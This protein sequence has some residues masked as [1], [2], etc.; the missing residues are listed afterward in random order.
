MDL[1]QRCKEAVKDSFTMKRDCNN[2]LK[3]IADETIDQCFDK[4]YELDVDLVNR[5]ST[6]SFE[7]YEERL[8]NQCVNS[9]RNVIQTIT[10]M[11]YENPPSSG[12]L[13][14]ECKLA[15]K[16]SFSLENDEEGILKDMMDKALDATFGEIFNTTKEIVES[17]CEPTKPMYNTLMI[18]GCIIIFRKSM[19]L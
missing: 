19:N 13:E 2:I 18:Q 9:F 17:V 8:I 5:D 16:K 7:N 14:D 3:T 11:E 15:V 10:A 6:T 1:K 4:L 12:P